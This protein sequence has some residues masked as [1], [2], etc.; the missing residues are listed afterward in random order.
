MDID[1]VELKMQEALAH[2][3]EELKK[4]RTG[5]ANASMVDGVFVEAYGTMMPLNQVASIQA[6]DA[7]LIVI[8]PFDPTTLN[9]ISEAIRSN[10]S[11]G[12]NPADDGKVVRVPIPPL[13]EERRKEFAKLIG[14]KAE[15]AKISLRNTRHDA[16]DDEKKREKSSE[17]SKD[18]LYDSEQELNKMIEKFNSKID[19]LSK[20]K[21][22][23]VLSV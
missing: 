12:L 9:A 20:Q 2:F 15:Q 16:L 7:T 3:E 21:E 10:H 6:T 18:D 4:I 1:E 23:E 19:S 14:E 8:T 13:T 5:R 22:S 11:L 17:I